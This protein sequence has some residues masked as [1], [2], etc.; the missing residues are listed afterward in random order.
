M[1]EDEEIGI[2][3]L[4]HDRRCDYH[5]RIQGKALLERQMPTGFAGYDLPANPSC[6]LA[7]LAPRLAQRSARQR[8]LRY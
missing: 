5:K 2:I 4:W 7:N 6:Y 8:F 3:V 1:I